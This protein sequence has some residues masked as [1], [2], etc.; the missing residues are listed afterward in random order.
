[1]TENYTSDLLIKLR[2]HKSNTLKQSKGENDDITEKWYE[3]LEY[4]IKNR[5]PINYVRALQITQ[6]SN[7]NILSIEYIYCEKKEYYNYIAINLFWK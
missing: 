3:T 6:D 7:Q 2:E 4:M 1:M 5:E